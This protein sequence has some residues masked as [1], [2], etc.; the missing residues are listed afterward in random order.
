MGIFVLYI[1]LVS[2]MKDIQRVFQYHGAEHKTI[3]CYEHGEAL[4]V[5]NVKK[6]SRLHP[7][8]GTSF[9]IEVMIIS[10]I[11][12]SFISWSNIWVRIGLKLLLMPLVAG[13]AYEFI[14]LAG[15]SD[16]PIVQLINKPGLWLQHL[17]TRE[18][19]GEQIE[20]G[21]RSLEEVLTGDKED[22]KW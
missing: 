11:V 6:Y 17:T 2:R 15:R 1:F 21:I 13:I 14:K 10:V 19:D 22:D 4:T 5:E 12:F 3:A 20:V 8:C 16:H 9:L 18:P 7:R